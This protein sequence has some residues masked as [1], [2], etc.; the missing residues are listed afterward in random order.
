MNAP[1]PLL[2]VNG[3]RADV[4]AALTWLSS[5]GAP[6]RDVTV[7]DVELSDVHRRFGA[8]GGM[9]SGRFNS[10]ALVREAVARLRDSARHELE[11]APEKIVIVTPK[12]FHPHVWQPREGGVALRLGRWVRRYAVL[13]SESP[14]GHVAHELGHL[15]FGWPDLDTVRGLGDGCL[16]ARGAERAGGPAPPCAALR[17]AAGWVEPESIPASAA[18]ECVSGAWCFERGAVRIVGERVGDVVLATR[19]GESGLPVAAVRAPAIAGQS[20]VASVAAALG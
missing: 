14:L 9:A 3:A 2:C 7:L 12:G 13:P 20:L 10:Q 15:L 17:A 11:L 4:A 1:L 8:S 18:V 6:L 16:M 5:W 19:V